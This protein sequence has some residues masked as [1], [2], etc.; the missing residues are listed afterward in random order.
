MR[1]KFLAAAVTI[2]AL[3][4]MSFSAYAAVD[5]YE[6]SQA[7]GFL[8]ELGIEADEL[9][10]RDAKMVYKDI[11]SASFN[12]PT[13]IDVLTERALEVG[14]VNIPEDGRA[15]YQELMDFHSLVPTAKISSAQVRAIEAGMSYE[16]IVSILGSTKDIGSGL[17]VLQYVVDGDKVL[18]LSFA[19]LLD[20][21]P[22]SG[23]EL[24]ETLQEAKQDKDQ[25]T[26]YATLI[27]KTGNGILVS[28]P[29]YQHFDM[30]SLAITQQTEIVFADGGVAAT[31]D[32]QG[33]LI[34]TI[35]G[36]VR[37]SY[38]P[39]AEAAKIVI[40]NQ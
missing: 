34:I 26:F 12:N 2:A 6:Y 3:A 32:I 30:V 14:I 38:P 5:Y 36:P 8:G 27:E 23:E 10:R 28:C 31:E 24:L 39:Q 40:K 20:T 19:N 7:E 9:S 4:T 29:T 21:C 13:T 33:E 18:N 37:E 15:I 11:K 16:E 22:K 25:D 35:T 17:Y 1:K